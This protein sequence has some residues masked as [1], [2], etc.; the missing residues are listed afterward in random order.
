MFA[1]ELR[2]NAKFQ[3]SSY[4]EYAKNPKSIVPKS[5]QTSPK[6]LCLLVE[7]KKMQ[8]KIGIKETR[9]FW[10]KVLSYRRLFPK[11]KVYSAFFSAGGF[12]SKAKSFCLENGIGIA[13]ELHI[14]I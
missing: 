11:Q 9:I 5:V 6:E 14:Q 12:T 1:T 8:E 4:F 3:F 13:T 10:E 7:M 2:S